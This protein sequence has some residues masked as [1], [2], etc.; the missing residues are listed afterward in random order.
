VYNGIRKIE[1]VMEYIETHITEELNYEVMASMMSLSL[2]EFRRIFSFIVGCPLSEYIR[3][4]RLSLAALEIMISDKADLGQISRKYGYSDQPAFSRAFL[5]QHGVSP[6][7]CARESRE[8]RLFTRPKLELHIYGGTDMPFVIEKKDSFYIQG[9]TAISAISDTCCCE[10]VWSAF[11]ESGWDKRIRADRIYASYANH[12]DSVA[13]CIG[14]IAGTG[15]LIPASRWACFRMNTAESGAVNEMYSKI[16]YDWLPSANLK[17]NKDI[18]TLEVFPLNMEED[19]FE[20]E[21]RIP[22]EQEKTK[23]QESF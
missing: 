15:Q 6:G 10:N 14:E 13:C 19:G 23:C 3:K 7:V 18:P 12:G 17:F 9:Y 8:I 1:E 21:I 16:V 5:G 2:Y 4:R 11:Y 22:I 20:W